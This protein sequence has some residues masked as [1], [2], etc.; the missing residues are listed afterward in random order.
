MQFLII[1]DALS[2][3]EVAECTAASEK[4]HSC[5]EFVTKQLAQQGPPGERNGENRHT[6]DGLLDC[7][8]QL[9]NVFE[10]EPHG[11]CFEPLIDHPSVIE[12]VRALFGDTFILHSSWNTMVPA[13]SQGGGFHQDGTSSYDFK[14][15]GN[16]NGLAGSGGPTPLVQLRIG[17]VL[18]DLS[19]PGV[20]NLA[21]VPGSH[22]SHMPL[23]PGLSAEELPI[24]Q[25]VCAKPG[26]AIMFHQ[27]TYHCGGTNSKPYN[28][29]IQHM[30]YSAPWLVRSGRV[31]ND[32][33]F[34]ARTTPMRRMLLGYQPDLSMPGG[35]Y[36]NAKHAFHGVGPLTEYLLQQPLSPSPAGGKL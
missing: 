24:A 20:G 28:R 13:N 19:E 6:G 12:K 21:L 18:T 25:E 3:E 17:F 1:P 26:T 22:N 4:I 23:P 7:W 31:S 29:Y 32:A 33:A 27:G 11:A 15:M 9:D 8:R 34:L 16:V 14:Q 30:A 35:G 5:E 36:S 10:C 2:P